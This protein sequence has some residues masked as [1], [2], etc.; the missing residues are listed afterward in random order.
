MI[1]GAGRLTKRMDERAQ[2][3]VDDRVR[4]GRQL[5]EQPD[6]EPIAFAGN[7][8]PVVMHIGVDWTKVV[9]RSYFVAPPTLFVPERCGQQV[10]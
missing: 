9:D 3:G 2:H 6:A 1:R 5:L 8:R 4:D 7:R 10:I